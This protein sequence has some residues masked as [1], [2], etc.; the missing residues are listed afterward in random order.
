[1]GYNCVAIW[2]LGEEPFVSLMG[3]HWEQ[4]ETKNPT[5]DLMGACCITSLA[6]SNFYS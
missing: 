4:K 3:T 6:Y 2:E 5:L 1:M